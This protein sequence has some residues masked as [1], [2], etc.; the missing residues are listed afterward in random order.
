MQQRKE[1]PIGQCMKTHAAVFSQR[2]GA[3]VIRLLCQAG[4]LDEF[5]PSFKFLAVLLPQRFALVRCW[6]RLALV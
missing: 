3:T 4:G 1:E 2:L 6:H 5:R